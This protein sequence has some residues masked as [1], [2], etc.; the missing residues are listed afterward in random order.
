MAGHRIY[1]TSLKSIY[2]HYVA[3]AEKNGRTKAEVD[4]IMHWLTGYSQEELRAKLD[5]G[6]DFESFFADAPELNPSR[7]RITGVVLRSAR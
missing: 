7:S 2:P 1:Q 5:D 6:S 3:K 4:E